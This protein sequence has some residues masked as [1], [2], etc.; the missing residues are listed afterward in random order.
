M[1]SRDIAD[2][3]ALIVEVPFI[4]DG[5]NSILASQ[6]ELFWPAPGRVIMRSPDGAIIWA[7]LH[8]KYAQLRE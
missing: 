1:I 6:T 3:L 2:S 8:P 4:E 5:K 7:A